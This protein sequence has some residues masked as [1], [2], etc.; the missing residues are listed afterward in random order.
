MRHRRGTRPRTRR[1]SCVDDSG[2]TNEDTQLSD[3][4]ACTDADGNTLTYSVVS[5]TLNGG[6]LNFNPNGSFTYD[7]APNFFGPASF[8]FKANDGDRGLEHRDYSITVNAVNDA[9]SFTAGDDVTVNEDSGGYSAAWASD[10]SAGP[11][12][13]SGQSVS[14]TVSNDN[15]ALFST[16]PAIAADGTLTFEPA[17]NANGSAT[18]TVSLS[19][20]GGTANGGDDTS[21]AVTFTITVNAV[22]DAPTAGDDSATTDEDNA[23]TVNV[24]A[25]DSAGPANESGQTLT[26]GDV[27]DPANGTAVDNGNGTITYTPDANFFGTDTFTYEVCDN[28]TPSLCDTATVTITVNPVNDAPVAVTT[29]RAPTRTRRSR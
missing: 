2:S 27:S 19:D 29:K 5:S 11:A 15:N 18:V 12:N 1:R 6:T 24:V 25:N 17:A 16:Q 28:G 3:S 14:F 22:N 10:I 23:V 7:P 9:P 20:D 26:V 4:V 13:E 21:A 8:T